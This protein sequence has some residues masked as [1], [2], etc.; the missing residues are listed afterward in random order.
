MPI[1]TINSLPP[2]DAALIARMLAEVRE[3]GAR[4]L[5]CP[6]A[7]IW[8]IFQPVP[9]ESYLVGTESPPVVIIKAQAGRSMQQRDAFVKAVSD[10]VAKGLSVAAGEVWI[11]YQEMSPADV[12]F[13]G[14]WAG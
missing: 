8:V 6:P 12:W 13:G 3:A 7:N 2:S 11:H 4:A 5:D 10:A 9:P 1:L 14:R